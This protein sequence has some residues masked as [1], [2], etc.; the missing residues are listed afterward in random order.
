MNNKLSN[1][2]DV[3]VTFTEYF[4]IGIDYVTGTALFIHG[5]PAIEWIAEMRFI[6]YPPEIID[7]N[8]S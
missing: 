4:P 5:F 2:D 8:L 7:V 6:N 3:V 1:R